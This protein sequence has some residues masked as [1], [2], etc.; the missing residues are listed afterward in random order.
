MASS[1]LANKILQALYKPSKP[2]PSG[3]GI[4]IAMKDIES[5]EKALESAIKSLTK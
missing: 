1:R 2:K 4:G 3:A 5:M